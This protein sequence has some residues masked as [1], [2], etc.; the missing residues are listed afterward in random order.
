MAD[1]VHTWAIGAE[2]TRRASQAPWLMR[3]GEREVR[4]FGPLA[5]TGCGVTWPGEPLPAAAPEQVRPSPVESIADVHERHEEQR[6]AAL[7]LE[8]TLAGEDW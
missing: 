4:W 8:V 5:C 2:R 3:A 1:H 7:E 6:A